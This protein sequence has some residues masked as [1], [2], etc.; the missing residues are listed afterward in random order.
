MPYR[1]FSRSRNRTQSLA[2]AISAGRQA[3]NHELAI[4]KIAR[5]P[6]AIDENTLPPQRTVLESKFHNAPF[7]VMRMVQRSD[8]VVPRV[9][10]H[11]GSESYLR[12]V[13]LATWRPDRCVILSA[14]NEV[15]Y[16]NA[17]PIATE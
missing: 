7:R 8:R 17:K 2:S 12:A 16:D 14:S 5:P 11:A 13:R 10:F 3:L 4:D 9:E 15:L 6:M 1:P